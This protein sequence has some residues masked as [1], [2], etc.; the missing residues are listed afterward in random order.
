[1]VEER[2]SK[3]GGNGSDDM[4]R[5]KY[6]FVIEIETEKELYEIEDLDVELELKARDFDPDAIVFACL[7]GVEEIS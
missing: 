3:S 2:V 1:M 6:T 5:N 7:A 4:P